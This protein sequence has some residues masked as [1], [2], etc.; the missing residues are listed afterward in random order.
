ML[1]IV[2]RGWSRKNDV[3][4]DEFEGNFCRIHSLYAFIWWWYTSTSD[5]IMEK[6]SHL[7]QNCSLFPLKEEEEKL[8]LPED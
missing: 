2:W 6:M 1:R 4:R 3:G 5:S 7:D 8:I